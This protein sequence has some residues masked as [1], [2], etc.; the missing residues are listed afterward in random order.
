M[1]INFITNFQDE[2]KILL[3][4][5]VYQSQRSQGTLLICFNNNIYFIEFI[6]PKKKKFN[7]FFFVSL[8]LEF[9]KVE[10][11]KFDQTERGD[12]GKQPTLFCF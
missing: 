2:K 5:R 4:G 7:G 9:T 3:M 11:Y 10:S 6:F 1:Y 8:N 12:Q